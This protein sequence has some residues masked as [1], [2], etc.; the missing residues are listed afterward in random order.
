MEKKKASYD[1]LLIVASNLTLA[2]VQA[3]H[4]SQMPYPSGRMS[5][6]TDKFVLEIFNRHK[7]RL[8]QQLDTS[9]DIL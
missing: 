7:D 8:E 1:T 4:T 3:T 9:G 5:P 6:T 2:E